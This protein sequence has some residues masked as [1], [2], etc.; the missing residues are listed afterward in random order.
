MKLAVREKCW[1]NGEQHL[2][3]DFQ[4]FQQIEILYYVSSRLCVM[5][6][7]GQLFTIVLVYCKYSLLFIVVISRT[8][9]HLKI[10]WVETLAFVKRWKNFI[11]N[12]F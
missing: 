6:Q 2:N 7:N 12:V 10:T 9:K 1:H 8:N 3:R 11:R 5:Y 4:Y